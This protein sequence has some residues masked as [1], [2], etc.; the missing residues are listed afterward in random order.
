VKLKTASVQTLVCHG[1]VV[2]TTLVTATLLPTSPASAQVVFD[3]SL[4]ALGGAPAGLV[5]GAPDYFVPINS[6]ILTGP[7]VNLLLHSFSQFDL[8]FGQSI[9]FESGGDISDVIARVT[10]GDGSSIAGVISADANLY[11]I[12]PRGITFNNGAQINV[13]GAFAASTADSILFDSGQ[14]FSVNNAGQFDSALLTIVGEPGGFSYSQA[15]PAPIE[16]SQL[17][18]R[19]GQPILLAGGDVFINGTVRA[20]GGL[21]EITG[22]SAPGIVDIVTDPTLA[23]TLLAVEINVEEDVSRADVLVDAG[24]LDVS[25]DDA[26][27]TF[28]GGSIG[29]KAGNIDLLNS[30][31][32]CGGIGAAADCGGGNINVNGGEAGN[33]LLDATERVRVLEGSSVV[34]RIEGDPFDLTQG[35]S[36]NPRDIFT[37]SDLFGSILIFADVV[38]IQGANSVL[39]ATS[40]GISGNAGLVSITAAS[41]VTISSGPLIAP[42]DIPGGL[43]SQVAPG[44]TG[45][46]GGISVQASSISVTNGA[47]VTSR[48]SGQGNAGLIQFESSETLIDGS[49]LLSTIGPGG[50]GE[51]GNI[52]ISANNSV[53][54]TN[55]AEVATK[56]EGTSTGNNLFAGN[57]LGAI[58]SGDF[59]NVVASVLVFG[60][61]VTIENNSVL[62]ATTTGQGNSGA[63]FVG[64]DRDIL[65]QNQGSIVSEVGSGIDAI[66]GGIFLV[67]ERLGLVNNSQISVENNGIGLAGLILG[68]AAVIALDEN[69]SIGAETESGLGG[70]IAFSGNFISL[71][72]NSN[73][74]TD[75]RAGAGDGGDIELDISD[76]IYA[77]PDRDNNITAQATGNGGNINFPASLFLRNIA[78]RDSDFSNSNDITADGAFSDG[79]IAFRSGV[80]DLNPV[81]E[82]V[83]LPTN[84]IDAS[85][86]I[87]QGCAAGN[88]TA[89]QEIGELVVT[90]RGGVPPSP[91]E[92]V[93]DAGG[94]PGLIDVPNLGAATPI[95]VEGPAD[96][97]PLGPQAPTASGPITWVEAQGWVYGEDGE[98]ILTASANAGAPPARIWLLPGCE[99][100]F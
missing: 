99:N 30:S 21:I 75:A 68:N 81:Q 94:G 5:P 37:A 77:S 25:T 43:Y 58:Q 3:G 65:L 63:I 36:G 32:I 15:S 49:F 1:V 53:T 33:I 87:A 41:E 23:N 85:R 100:V 66:G 8:D 7:N 12:D 48:S 70:G 86:L 72:N 4:E 92:Q 24:I 13:A 31:A 55:G 97:R 11:L 9:F 39:S 19:P 38:E 90:G 34:N 52:L 76:V 16:I 22:L 46:A 69:S 60:D 79:T 54:L 73:I 62:T 28:D 71:S 51:A 96:N 67:S 35:A 40:R 91:S 17:T 45:D 29:I 10:A 83:T 50:L 26:L 98:V 44:T 27:V 64:A 61:F 18:G 57:L 89:A 78:P 59:S 42:D 80:Q 56:L 88:L 20:R 82:Q 95:E 84:L 74:R 14:Q 2:A 93:I 47:L 6:G